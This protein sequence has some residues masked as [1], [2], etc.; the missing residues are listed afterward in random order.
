MVPA[1]RQKVRSVTV[2]LNSLAPCGLAARGT[3]LAAK[4]LEKVEPV[5]EKEKPAGQGVK[6]RK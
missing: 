2:N 5:P 6:G 3:K 4:P 1:K